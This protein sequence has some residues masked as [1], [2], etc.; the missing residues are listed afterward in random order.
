M[1]GTASSIISRGLLLIVA[2]G[3]PCADI[4]SAPPL[5]LPAVCDAASHHH[6]KLASTRIQ[7]RAHQEV[8]PQ[9]RAWLLRQ[10]SLKVSALHQDYDQ[11]QYGVQLSQPLIKPAAWFGLSRADNKVK[12]ALM[13]NR[14]V[15]RNIVDVIQAKR[16]WF[17][18]RQWMIESRYQFPIEWVKLHW[19]SGF[20]S[21]T[22]PVRV[23]HWLKR[24]G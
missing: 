23:N 10:L 8:L 22:S 19:D 21:L 11:V 16:S 12:E 14:G 1:P 4:K 6:P 5:S 18:V 7:Y 24:T 9:A 15:T 17:K 13:G 3:G 2:L 20:L